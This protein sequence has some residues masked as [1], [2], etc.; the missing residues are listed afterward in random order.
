MVLTVV[1][2]TVVTVTIT[3][4]DTAE[5]AVANSAVLAVAVAT[6]VVVQLLIGALTQPT[7]AAVA[8]ITLV[9]IRIMNPDS[10]LVMASL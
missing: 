9:R 8:L 5:V 4:V 2:V 3:A 1:P 10:K 6:P 7:A